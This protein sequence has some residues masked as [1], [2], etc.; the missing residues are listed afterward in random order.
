MRLPICDWV[1]SMNMRDMGGTKFAFGIAR[2]RF[3]NQYRGLEKGG[4]E[5]QIKEPLIFKAL[6]IQDFD[7]L[8]VTR[9]QCD[10]VE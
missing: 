1:I 8:G 9:M 2:R 6:L 10:E 7:S 3:Q 4:A 5:G